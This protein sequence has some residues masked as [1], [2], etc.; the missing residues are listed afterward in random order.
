MEENWWA[1][2]TWAF[3][4]DMNADG[5]VTISDVLLWLKW[6]YFMPGDCVIAILGP[7]AIGRFLELTTSSYGSWGSGMVS[8]FL[9]TIILGIAISIR[10]DLIGTNT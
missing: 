1:Y 7:T 9:W 2:R 6:L 8:L 3:V 4:S 5:S 10:D